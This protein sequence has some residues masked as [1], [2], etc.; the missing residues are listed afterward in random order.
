MINSEGG[1][2]GRPTGV[3][4]SSGPAGWVTVEQSQ[5]VKIEVT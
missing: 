2:C 5:W 3:T 1:F 4:D